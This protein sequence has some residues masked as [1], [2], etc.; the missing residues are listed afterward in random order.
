[1]LADYPD[2]NPTGYVPGDADETLAIEDVR[3]GLLPDDKQLEAAHTSSA[4]WARHPKR[5]D[6][7][8]DRDRSMP[9]SFHMVRSMGAGP[10]KGWV[11]AF[12]KELAAWVAF[13][14]IMAALAAF[15]ILT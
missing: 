15:W 7:P 10:Q 1:M 2:N 9:D 4:W 12:W 13:I 5:Y 11:Q 14:F 3:F 6:P 8:L